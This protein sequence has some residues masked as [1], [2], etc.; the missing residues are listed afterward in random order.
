MRGNDDTD[1]PINSGGYSDADFAAD[2]SD[3]KSVTGGL[4]EVA[5]MLVVWFTCKHSGVSLS[6]MEAEYTA[7][8]LV[9]AEMI[10][11]KELLGEMGISCVTPMSLKV[12]NQAALKLLGGE[13]SSKSRHIDVRIKFVGSHAKR[14]ILKVEYCEGSCMPADLMTKALHPPRLEELKRLVG[15]HTT[16]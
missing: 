8:S 5:S 10:G 9:V 16:E 6:T 3:R 1:A 4:I 7:A 12:D 14:G 2:K 15:L 13:S 11:I